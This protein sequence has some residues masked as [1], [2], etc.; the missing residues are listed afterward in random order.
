MISEEGGVPDEHSLSDRQ[1]VVSRRGGSDCAL[2]HAEPGGLGHPPSA[3]Q[4]LRVGRRRVNGDTGSYCSVCES[5][6][7]DG[8]LRRLDENLLH[9]LTVAMEELGTR[10]A[11]RSSDP[12]GFTE[13][14]RA[15]ALGGR[16]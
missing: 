11:A 9:Y 1:C 15:S 7:P 6:V 4:V 10:R 5:E 13:G 2:D 16:A 12:D 3:R 8:P 14:I